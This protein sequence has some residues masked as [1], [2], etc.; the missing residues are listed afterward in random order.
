MY[1]KKNQWFCISP[2]NEI[3]RKAQRFNDYIFRMQNTVKANFEI[4]TVFFLGVD[5]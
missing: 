4:L 2:L 3:V 1:K 5:K